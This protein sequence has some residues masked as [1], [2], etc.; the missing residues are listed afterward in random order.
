M[1]KKSLGVLAIGTLFAV[2]T[3]TPGAQKGAVSHT[4]SKQQFEQWKKDLSN[5]GRWGNDDQLGAMN[6]IT[7][8]KRKQAADLVRDGVTVSLASDADEVKSVDNPN[9]YDHRMMGI[10]ADY[11]GVAMHGWAHTHLDSLAH[12]NDNGVFFNGYTPN[13]D[14]IRKDTRTCAQFAQQREER[15]LH[16]RRSPR[17]PPAEGREV[18]RAG[19]T[20]LPGRY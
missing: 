16:A 7:A 13:P 2:M 19:H 20:D 11:I 15:N 9:P 17:H 1:R 3:V 6:L 8:A 4:I 5:W 18:P 12:V 10:G 14:T